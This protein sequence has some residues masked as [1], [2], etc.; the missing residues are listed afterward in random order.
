MKSFIEKI[1]DTAVGYKMWKQKVWQLLH[2]R[3]FSKYAMNIG[4]KN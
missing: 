2:S 4:K 1:K 3:T